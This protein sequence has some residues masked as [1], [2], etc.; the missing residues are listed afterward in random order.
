MA[1]GIGKA[2]RWHQVWGDR[3]RPMGYLKNQIREH[4]ECDMADH[5]HG[6]MDTTT[7]QKTFDGFMRMVTWGAGISIGVLIFIAL[8]NG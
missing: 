7:Q 1:H 6:K 8:V 4:G 5:E 2:L 3:P